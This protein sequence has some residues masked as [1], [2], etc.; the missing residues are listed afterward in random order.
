[1]R[2]AGVIVVSL[3]S[4]GTLPKITPVT[5]IAEQQTT[6]GIAKPESADGASSESG[7]SSSSSSS[8]SSGRKSALAT[9]GLTL[10]TNLIGLGM[11]HFNAAAEIDLAEHWAVSVPFYYSGGFNYF[12]ETVKFRGIVIQPEAR[13]Y[14]KDNEGF[15]MGAHLGL[16]WYNFA[17]DGEYTIPELAVEEYDVLSTI[18]KFSDIIKSSA[19][20]YEPSL[21]TRY[22]LELSGVFNKF[23]MNC[24]IACEDEN[25]KKF[26][27]AI[28]KAVKIT[29][30]NA[31]TLLGIETVEEM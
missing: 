22:A 25:L 29:L 2:W 16:G 28:T 15:Y 14:L 8:S 27:L 13:Y 31:L 17:V 23:Y 3:E 21:V 5:S 10:K 26:R 19:R 30:T 6:S 18:S 12:K 20:N 11:G 1:M 9:R 7:D 24:K 4:T